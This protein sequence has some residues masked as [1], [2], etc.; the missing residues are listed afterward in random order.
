[1]IH[2][3]NESKTF[4]IGM[5]FISGLFV[6]KFGLPLNHKAFSE[7]TNVVFFIYLQVSVKMEEFQ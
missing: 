6:L 7:K 4:N 3:V 5:F 2:V 1:M